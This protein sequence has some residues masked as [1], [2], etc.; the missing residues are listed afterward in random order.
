M[1]SRSNGGFAFCWQ[2]EDQDTSKAGIFAQVFSKSGKLVSP[3]FKINNYVLDD[4]I[5]C[6]LRELKNQRIVFVWQSWQ[7]DDPAEWGIYGRVFNS[8]GVAMTNEF[9]INSEPYLDQSLPQIDTL[10]DGGFVAVWQ[11]SHSG[12]GYDIYARVFNA[13][14]SARYNMIETRV[15]PIIAGDQRFPAVAVLNNQSIVICWTASDPDGLGIYARIFDTELTPLSDE[16]RVNVDTV[17]TQHYP[18]V[19]SMDDGGYFVIWNSQAVKIVGRIF[20]PNAAISSSEIALATDAILDARICR[21]KDGKIVVVWQ[22]SSTG[23]DVEGIAGRVINPDGTLIGTPFLINDYKSSTQGSPDCTGLEDGGFVVAWDSLNQDGDSGGIFAKRYTNTLKERNFIVDCLNEDGTTSECTDP[24]NLVCDLTENRCRPCT[25]SS[26]CPESKP[27]CNPTHGVCGNCTTNSHCPDPNNFICDQRT[28][29]CRGCVANSECPTSSICDTT[30]GRCVSC[31]SDDDCDPNFPVCDAVSKTCRKCAT[32]NECHSNTPYCIAQL[33]TCQE[34]NTHQACRDP[35]Y[36]VCHPTLYI[37]ATCI[38]QSCPAN[39]PYC[40]SIAGCVECLTD[41]HCDPTRPYCDPSILTC[42][43]CVHD[44]DCPYSTSFCSVERKCIECL[45]DED[46]VEMGKC[47]KQSGFCMTFESLRIDNDQII[48]IGKLIMGTTLAF[49]FL[50]LVHASTMFADFFKIYQLLHYATFFN[51]NHPYNLRVVLWIFSVGRLT[52]LPNIGNLH[53]LEEIHISAPRKFEENEYSGF[54]LR[55]CGPMLFL[56]ACYLSFL[57]TLWMLEGNCTGKTFKRFKNFIMSKLT[58]DLW[59]ATFPE[60]LYASLLQMLELRGYNFA[61]VMSS[62]LSF[63]LTIIVLVVMVLRGITL[64]RMDPTIPIIHKWLPYFEHVRRVIQP[65]GM[66]F[67]YN[68]PLQQ[69]SVFWGLNLLYLILLLQLDYMKKKFKILQEIITLSI[70]GALTL[71]ADDST[72]L[73]YRNKVGWVVIILGGLLIFA[74]F[75]VTGDEGGLLLKILLYS[76]GKKKVTIRESKNSRDVKLKMPKDDG[77]KGKKKEE[78]K[79]TGKPKSRGGI[80]KKT[81]QNQFGDTFFIKM[82]NSKFFINLKRRFG[83]K[84]KEDPKHSRKKAILP[85]LDI[86][87]K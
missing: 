31:V 68:F 76:P 26:E 69:L 67:F 63:V 39:K 25:S 14:G 52:V 79:K 58:F 82:N 37:C 11:S 36:P 64:Y 60:I 19:A 38:S 5:N 87:K 47:D 6:E 2:S 53:S 17:G 48:R 23:G 21:L 24:F 51:I 4:Q 30:T 61:V 32:D 83:I 18:H 75:L 70:Y 41:S 42:S 49:S 45:E 81:T 55:T 54:L 13:D 78:G 8:E 33:G 1:A 43:I 9:H 10:I 74:L 62:I 3:E 85:A 12:L 77:S 44:S 65:F 29:S 16:F 50:Y 56:W 35:L 27:F 86:K 71:L 73:S 28:L 7:Q 22:S 80:M 34:C 59:D 46:C 72:A 66:V 20:S 15:N 40:H 84:P 57:M